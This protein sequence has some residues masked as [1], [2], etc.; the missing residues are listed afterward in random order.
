MW[1]FKIAVWALGCTAVPEQADNDSELMQ[2]PSLT[3]AALVDGLEGVSFLNVVKPPVIR[4]MVHTEIC[5]SGLRPGSQWTMGPW[6]PRVAPLRFPAANP[7]E[8]QELYA[9]RPEFCA[10]VPGSRGS[11]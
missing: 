9:P 6:V 3:D 1:G 8:R 11:S 5:C 10:A 4:G 2:A 7:R